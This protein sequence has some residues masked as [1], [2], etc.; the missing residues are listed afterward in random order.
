[1]KNNTRLCH[2]VIRP[3]QVI[4]M[5]N[6]RLAGEKLIACPLNHFVAHYHFSP[7][8]STPTHSDI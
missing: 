1:M 7:F 5:R 4:R 8:L 6:V 3:L 2:L